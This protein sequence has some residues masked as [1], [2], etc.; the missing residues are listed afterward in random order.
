MSNDNR[1]LW[2]P[3]KRIG[4]FDPANVAVFHS[5]NG[6]HAP[7]IAPVAGVGKS[8]SFSRYISEFSDGRGFRGLARRQRRV[9][10]S[11]HGNIVS[12]P[13]S[14]CAENGW[15]LHGPSNRVSHARKGLKINFDGR[16]RVW[17]PGFN[18]YCVIGGIITLYG[19]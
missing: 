4:H 9:V 2:T 16:S 19:F 18:S 13:R 15:G 10:R 7:L 14:E 11:L 6:L 1:Q 3:P 5:K 8:P 12:C 17:T